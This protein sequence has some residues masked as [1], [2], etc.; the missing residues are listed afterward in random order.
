M[1]K[2]DKSEKPEALWALWS[3]SGRRYMPSGLADPAKT[4]RSREAAELCA[5]LSMH[6]KAGYRVVTLVSLELEE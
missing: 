4:F 5:G 3:D 1:A 6:R 2:K